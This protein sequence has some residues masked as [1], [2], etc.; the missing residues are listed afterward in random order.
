MRK[1]FMTAVK[2]TAHALKKLSVSFNDVKLCREEFMSG[3]SCKLAFELGGNCAMDKH[4]RNGSLQN[5]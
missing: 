4:T 2:K 3:V 5:I 1:P